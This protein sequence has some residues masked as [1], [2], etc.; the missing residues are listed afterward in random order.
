M[1][2]PCTTVP[3]EVLVTRRPHRRLPERKC[4]APA[5]V[6]PVLLPAVI[7]RPRDDGPA[8]APLSSM[9][10]T[11]AYPGCVVPSRTTGPVIVGRADRG[12]MV[13]GPLPLANVTWSAP[14][15]ALA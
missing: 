5:A 3:R 6:P 10:G 1:R 7:V 2:F 12:L 4:P 8:L 9:R 11:P 14:G 13:C 15:W